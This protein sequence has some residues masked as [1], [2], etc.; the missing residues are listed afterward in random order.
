M[1]FTHVRLRMSWKKGLWARIKGAQDSGKTFLPPIITEGQRKEMI[2]GL[3]RE[4]KNEMWLVRHK[5]E[6]TPE[7]VESKLSFENEVATDSVEWN[8]KK[9]IAEMALLPDVTHED[10]LLNIA[11]AGNQWSKP[12]FQK[13]PDLNR[14]LEAQINKQNTIFRYPKPVEKPYSWNHKQ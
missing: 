12:K 9:L 10:R 13:Y 11:K 7:K 8:R 6:E 3:W 1:R 5:Y 14:H 4:A 2:D